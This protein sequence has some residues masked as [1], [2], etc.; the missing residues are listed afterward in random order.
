MSA[1]NNPL[2]F[3][4]SEL[5][6]EAYGGGCFGVP[7]RAT[8]EQNLRFLELNSIFAGPEGAPGRPGFS[9]CLSVVCVTL[10]ILLTKRKGASSLLTVPVK[11]QSR[12]PEIQ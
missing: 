7:R 9:V 2:P 3:C 8:V 6:E 5:A 4:V 10:I 11:T 1:N 12:F